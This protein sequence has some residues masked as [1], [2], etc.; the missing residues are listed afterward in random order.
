MNNPKIED[1][2]KEYE[3]L[4]SKVFE[5][6]QLA[7]NKDHKI[8]FLGSDLDSLVCSVII[9]YLM[10]KHQMIYS[11]ATNLVRERYLALKPIPL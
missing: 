2:A 8:L 5:I 7:I 4:C 10:K 3:A 9:Y 11:S 1:F 6:I